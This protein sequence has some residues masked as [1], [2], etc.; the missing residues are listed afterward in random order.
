MEKVV[1]KGTQILNKPLDIVGQNSTVGKIR[2]ALLRL[3]LL[4]IMIAIIVLSVYMNFLVNLNKAPKTYAFNKTNK[5]PLVTLALPKI[6]NDALLNWASQAVSDIFT[7][8]FADNLDN[9]FEKVKG[10]FTA[11]GYA[12]YME[13]VKSTGLLNDILSKQL[14]YAVNSCDVVTVLNQRQT[15]VAGED[16]T[17]WA[18]QIPILMQ[19]QSHDPTKLFRYL[20]TLIIQ[21]GEEVSSDKSIGIASISM[22]LAGNDFCGARGLN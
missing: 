17:I 22:V 21:S 19:I 13:S 2:L 18:V 8:N 9:H 12:Q 5:T 11:D 15:K 7:F 14:A 4:G 1:K 6:S 10:Y 16:V 3:C 20:V